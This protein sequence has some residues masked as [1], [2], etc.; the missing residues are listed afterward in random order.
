MQ[1]HQSSVWRT[2]A[3]VYW[4]LGQ[5]RVVACSEATERNHCARSL[6]ALFVLAQRTLRLS[7]LQFLT[8]VLECQSRHT[9]SFSSALEPTVHFFPADLLSYPLPTVSKEPKD[10]HLIINILSYVPHVCLSASRRGLCS[11]FLAWHVDLYIQLNNKTMEQIHSR[12]PSKHFMEQIQS[13]ENLN[14]RRLKLISLCHATRYTL[15]EPIRPCRL[16]HSVNTLPWTIL[17][18]SPYLEWYCSSVIC[19]RLNAL[20]LNR[21]WY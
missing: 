16:A 18:P 4:L 11:S 5:A 19:H 17:K 3:R 21:E 10:I 14:S 9:C 6:G 1:L 7:C 13:L 12:Q 20:H 2:A 8:S 15:N